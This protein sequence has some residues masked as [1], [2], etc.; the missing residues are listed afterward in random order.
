MIINI[1]VSMKVADKLLFATF[2]YIL[3]SKLQK[4][5]SINLNKFIFIKI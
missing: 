1:S 5:E 3:G 2:P 4:I